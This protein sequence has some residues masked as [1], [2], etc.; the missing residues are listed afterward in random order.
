[1][2]AIA[3]T[4]R[5]VDKLDAVPDSSFL[6]QD[7]EYLVRLPAAGAATQQHLAAASA[8]SLSCHARFVGQD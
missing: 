6:V 7:H 4:S 1:M 3:Q 8:A 2:A 5:D